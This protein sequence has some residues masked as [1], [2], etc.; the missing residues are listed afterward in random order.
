MQ[1]TLLRHLAAMKVGLNS[2][3]STIALMVQ[4]IYSDTRLMVLIALAM[5]RVLGIV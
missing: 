5:A 2:I 3:A 1:R 4:E